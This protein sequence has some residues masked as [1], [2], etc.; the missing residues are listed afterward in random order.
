MPCFADGNAEV[1]RVPFAQRDP[2][3]HDQRG[4]FRQTL[5]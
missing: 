5:C 3:D 4:R 1:K 2:R